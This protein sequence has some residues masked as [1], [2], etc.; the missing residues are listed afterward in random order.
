MA[1]T[2]TKSKNKLLSTKSMPLVSL[3]GKFAL[4]AIGLCA[5]G[6]VLDQLWLDLAKMPW[7]ILVL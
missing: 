2:L 7:Q 4:V 3:G 1:W 6:V 5:C